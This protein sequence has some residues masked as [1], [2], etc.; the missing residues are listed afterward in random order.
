MEVHHDVQKQNPAGGWG[1][2]GLLFVARTVYQDLPLP[3][4]ALNTLWLTGRQ[5]LRA[6]ALAKRGCAGGTKTVV[7]VPVVRVVVVAVR[8][9]GVIPVGVE[10]TAAHPFAEPPPTPKGC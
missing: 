2:K 10:R 5:W 3:G 9:L 4:K 6:P 1:C 7:V 8:A